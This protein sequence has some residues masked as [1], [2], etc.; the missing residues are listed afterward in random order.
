MCRVANQQK[1]V[2]EAESVTECD[3]A[4]VSARAFLFTYADAYFNSCARSCHSVLCVFITHS[5]APHSTHF[6]HKHIHSA[7]AVRGTLSVF[8]PSPW[9]HK[10]TTPRVCHFTQP[11]HTEDSHSASFL[12][13]NTPSVLQGAVGSHAVYWLTHKQFNAYVIATCESRDIC[14]SN[15]FSFHL[16]CSV[17]HPSTLGVCM[18]VSVCSI[19]TSTNFNKYRLWLRSLNTWQQCYSLQF[20][21]LWTCYGYDIMAPVFP[22]AQLSAQLGLVHTC[23]GISLNKA[24]SIHPMFSSRCSQSWKSSVHMLRVFFSGFWHVGDVDFI[25]TYWPGMSVSG[26]VIAFV[27]SYVRIFRKNDSCVDRI[28]FFQ[29]RGVC[30]MS[31]TCILVSAC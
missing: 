2:C 21:L 7:P 16:H 4:R 26:F 15:R 31:C 8:L 14:C 28:V 1:N 22:R 9:G 20:R 30:T 18:F 12:L 11:S 23:V 29:Q 10:H 6:A 13:K 5:Q 25:A 3:G 24:F 27:V 19:S 17:C